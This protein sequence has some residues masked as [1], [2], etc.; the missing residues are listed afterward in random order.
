MW[1][2]GGAHEHIAEVRHLDA[3]CESKGAQRAA[4]GME[5]TWVGHAVHKSF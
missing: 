5:G 3:G 2:S 1:F 4:G